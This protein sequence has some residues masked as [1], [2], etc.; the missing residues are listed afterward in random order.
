MDFIVITAANNLYINTIIDFIN[1]YSLDMTTLVVYDL[2]MNPDNLQRLQILNQKHI[3]NLKTFEYDNYPDYVN[4]NKWSGLNCSYAFKPIILYNEAN[5]ILNKNKTII[6]MDSANRFNIHHITS[7]CSIVKTQGIYTPIAVNSGTIE[8]IELN[9]HSVVKAYGLSDSEH[10]QQL[11]TISANLIGFDYT[12]TAG[13]GIIKKWYM[14]S[15]NKSLIIPEGTN[16]NN[17]R[18]D[19]T[20]LSLLI[21]LYEK[22]NK[23]VLNKANIGVSFWNKK[24]EITIDKIYIPFKLFDRQT[25]QQLAIIY[26]KDITEAVTVYADRKNIPIPVFLQHFVVING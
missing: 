15:L 17:N 21:Y 22:Y 16:R 18:Q 25:Q 19:Q 26:C 10:K 23:I 4:V 20:I 7:I 11:Q 1:T 9:H 5:I 12:S 24:D 2:G 8:S 6:W 3:F 14:D 13:F